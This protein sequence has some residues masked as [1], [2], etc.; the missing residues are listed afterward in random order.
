MNNLSGMY[1]ALCDLVD[2]L[3]YDNL[4]VLAAVCGLI[5]KIAAFKDN[6]KIMIDAGIVPLLTKLVTAVIYAKRIS[7]TVTVTRTLEYKYY[8]CCRPYFFY[9]IP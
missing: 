5:E 7:Q 3:T 1:D 4:D 2:L 9:E 8:I 6:L